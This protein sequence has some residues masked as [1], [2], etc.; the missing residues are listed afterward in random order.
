VV[1]PAEAEA[2][3]K[4]CERHA[5]E[6]EQLHRNLSSL[7][8]RVAGAWTGTAGQSLCEVIDDHLRAVNGAKGDLQAAARDIRAAARESSE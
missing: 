1:A 6:L 2:Q 7:R 3:A 8:Q 5:R 4:A